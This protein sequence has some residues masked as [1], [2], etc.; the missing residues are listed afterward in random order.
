MMEGLQNRWLELLSVVFV[1]TMIYTCM[2]IPILTNTYILT[3]T[4]IYIHTHTYLSLLLRSPCC[5]WW[6]CLR[7]AALTHLTE[8]IYIYI[9]TH[10]H[11]HIYI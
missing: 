5:L 6:S 2:Y 11:I 4:Y 10:T 8:H 9:Y 3:Y 7:H 1:A